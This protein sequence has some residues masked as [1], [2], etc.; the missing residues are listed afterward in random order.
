[1]SDATVAYVT[2][3]RKHLGNDVSFAQ[4]SPLM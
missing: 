2:T 1:M 4:K 3:V